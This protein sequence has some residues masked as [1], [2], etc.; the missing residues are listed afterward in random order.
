[1]NTSTEK[2][3]QHRSIDE[4][5]EW[6]V[7]LQDDDVC[8]ETKEAFAEW[9]LSS[10]NHVRDYLKLAML[11]EDIASLDASILSAEELK[12]VLAEKAE[13]ADIVKLFDRPASI[14]AT[15]QNGKVNS[16]KQKAW[17]SGYKLFAAAAAMVMAVGVGLFWPAADPV[18]IYQT[19]LG[20][21]SS[22]AL[23]DGSL[24]VMNTQTEIQVD[25]DQEH[26]NLYLNSGEAFFDVAKDPT[27]AFR[28]IVDGAVIEALGTSFNVRHFSNYTEATLLEG[29]ISVSAK[30]GVEPIIVGISERVRINHETGS[31]DVSLVSPDAILAWQNRK[32]IFDGE[33]LSDAISEFN[34]YNKRKVTI[35]DAV[36]ASK[37][38]SG[39][40]N[41]DDPESFTLFL[42]AAGI[43]RVNVSASGIV[44][45]S[46]KK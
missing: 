17:S 4:A 30:P 11:S 40:F 35:L 29:A 1:M 8:T 31:V 34:R 39:V 13:V 23:D 14:P 16:K 25:M 22:M 42:E 37:K 21:Q 44:L 18:I 9:L 15:S 28:V 43:A 45:T 19:A 24:L 26:R 33:L 7:L 41:A 5:A 38:V 36:L 3:K 12:A 20:E 2:R 6:L 46:V 32:L 27:R 10:R